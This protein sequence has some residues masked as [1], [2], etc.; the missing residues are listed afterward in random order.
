MSGTS[1]NSRI[2]TF[3]GK[4]DGCCVPGPPLGG[5]FTPSPTILPT[6][7]ETAKAIRYKR[8]PFAAARPLPG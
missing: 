8:I 7:N 2:Q 4:I 1:R 5:P 3:D 6:S